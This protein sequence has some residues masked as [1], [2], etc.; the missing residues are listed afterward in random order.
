MP[1]APGRYRLYGRL[2]TG[3]AAPEAAFAEAGV[4]IDLIDV[5]GDAAEAEA[6]GYLRINPRGQVPAL[7]LPD[8]SAIAEGPAILLHVADAFPAARL[9]PAP[10]SFAR[11]RHDRWLAFFHA[12]V[13]EGELRRFY[14][15]RYTTDAGCTGA[16]QDAAEAYVKHHYALFEAELGDG[17]F[18]TGPDLTV[19]DIY[20][21]MLVQWFDRPWLM[22]HTP[23]LLALTNRVARRRAVAPVHARH[24]FTDPDQG[25]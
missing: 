18:A 10:G 19:L 17:P 23:K 25:G 15:D 2:T 13:Y 9:A 6:T 16:V 4:A 12:N 7:V 24:F 22:T 3:S 5:P 8:G 20:I 11:A 21:W 14:P 1:P